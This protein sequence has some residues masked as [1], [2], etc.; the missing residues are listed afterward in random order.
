[1]QAALRLAWEG[2]SVAI[3]VTVRGRTTRH[4]ADWVRAAIEDN[5][6]SEAEIAR[7]LDAAWQ[8]WRRVFVPV[9]ATV[10]LRHSPGSGITVQRFP[11]KHAYFTALG[12][13][14]Y[15]RQT[16]IRFRPLTDRLLAEEQGRSRGLRIDRRRDYYPTAIPSHEL[17][18][19]L[20]LNCAT[21][22]SETG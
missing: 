4:A 3:D 13:P 17:R 7:A 6:A 15:R 12:A 2:G 21:Q 8:E 1:V 22:Q 11:P 16:E 18:A 14:W 9:G 19:D 10:S 20:R 5:T